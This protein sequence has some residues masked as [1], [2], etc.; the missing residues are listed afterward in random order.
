MENPTHFQLEVA[1][2]SYLQ[3]LGD[4]G[5]YTLE[6]L[7]ELKIHLIDNVTELKKKDLEEEE[8][9]LIAKKRLGKEEELGN[10]FS[11]V[12]GNKFYNRDLFVLV[13]SV[14]TYLFLNYFYSFLGST[15][16]NFAI[17]QSKNIMIWG[18]INYLFIIAFAISVMY[19][20]FNCKSYINAAE[21]L[22]KRSPVNFSII[23]IA[24]IVM[25]YVFN[26]TI[27][28]KIF[29]TD[30]LSSDELSNRYSALEINHALGSYIISGLFCVL[31]LSLVITF[32]KSYKKVNVLQ[33]IINDSGY[34]PLFFVGLFWDGVA[35]SSRMIHHH[36]NLSVYTFGI[37]WLIGMTIFNV[38]LRKNIL[39]RNFVFIA[40]GFVFE[41]AAGLWMNPALREG[42][43][44]SVY[45]IAL[46]VGSATGYGVANFIKKRK[47]QVAV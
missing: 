32:I 19:L 30:M 44:V 7:M 45:F 17:F 37:V 14:S 29:K 38:H 6:D 34:I 16:K 46:V 43:P 11:K 22:F 21:K 25:V 12:N 47:L 3:Q 8:A 10:E 13:L 24:I 1:V 39:I 40:F 33:N 31:I 41:L 42:T 2:D 27:G 9:F 35:A 18:I 15:I 26:R 28:E 20:L 5:N 23:L 36:T 4:K